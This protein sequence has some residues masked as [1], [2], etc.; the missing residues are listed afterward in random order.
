MRIK[1]SGAHPCGRSPG[2]PSIG[3]YEDPVGL[4]GAVTVPVSPMRKQVLTGH[5]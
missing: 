2:T 5:S 4:A 1:G 3:S